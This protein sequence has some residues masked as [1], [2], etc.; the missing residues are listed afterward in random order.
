[1]IPEKMVIE[2]FQSYLRRTEVRFSPGV[3]AIFGKV[4]DGETSDSNGAGKSALMPNALTW[5]L[6]GQVPSG[7]K[8][9]DLMHWDAERI[10]GEVFL[11]GRGGSL[12]VARLKTRKGSETVD[13]TWNGEEYKLDLRP[14][15]EML[16]EIYGIS[17]DVYCNAI[18]VDSTSKATQFVT[19]TPG[20][21]MKL[22]GEMIPYDDL[23][24]KA[25]SAVQKDI[26]KLEED[27]RLQ[28][29]IR[30]RVVAELV[31]AQ[32]SLSRV[33]TSVAGE[34][35]RVQQ[36]KAVK[37]KRLREL[38]LELE[39]NKEI[40]M[41]P[42]PATIAEL[43]V[44]KNEALNRQ[45][46]AAVDVGKYRAQAQVEVRGAG[47]V[48][49][50]C[51]QVVAQTA[52]LHLR[53]ER[54]QAERLLASAAEDLQGSAKEVGVL[55]SAIQNALQAISARKAAEAAVQRIEQD[56]R[57]LN[58]QEE[59]ASLEAL[60]REHKIHV[61]LVKSLAEGLQSKDKEI[62]EIENRIPVLRKLAKGF[63]QDLR[64]MLLDDIRQVLAYYA[65]KYRWILYGD[66]MTV[67]FPPTTA[68]GRE[69]FDIIFRTGEN[70][71]KLPSKGQKFRMALAVILALRRVLI[72]GNRTPFEFLVLDDPMGE[73]DDTGLQ[74][75]YKLMQNLREEIPC[76]LTTAPR[77]LEGVHFDSEV[78]VEFQNRES[79]I[80]KEGL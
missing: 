6:W 16:E 70:V 64:N 23:F 35:H 38:Q 63:Q 77:R 49:P 3:N 53:Q 43:Q 67:E 58:L 72:F 22:L 26:L 36:E 24:Q 17:W 54:E 59:P 55:D 28:A 39:R 37:E 29:G 30:E 45:Q 40:L 25:G 41:A 18:V 20:Q 12:R 57:M 61:E 48:C 62:E 47:E 10:F 4:G 75:L 11:A 76:V 15:Q 68:T 14:A 5:I 50:T 42:P 78:W 9:S 71:N 32:A 74:C 19:A 34:T 46:R 31:R 8:A 1:M 69:K 65:D 44:K 51:R 73:L 33:V 27:R 80:V 60:K 2:G 7:E 56:I 13:F 79:R 21:R 52:A 66:N